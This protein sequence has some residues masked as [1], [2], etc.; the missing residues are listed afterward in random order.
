MKRTLTTP[1]LLFA[2]ADVILCQ[3]PQASQIEPDKQTLA[4]H[5]SM[6]VAVNISLPGFDFRSEVEQKLRETGIT[7]LNSSDQQVAYPALRLSLEASLI[8]RFRPP[9]LDYRIGLEFVQLFTLR[10]G[11]YAKAATWSANHSGLLPWNGIESATDVVSGVQKE[12]LNLVD[13]F[14][15][16]WRDVNSSAGQQQPEGGAPSGH[17]DGIWRGSYSCSGGFGGGTT[18]WRIREVTPGN[19]QIVEQWT[20]FISGRNSYQGRI[21][22]RTLDVTTVETSNGMSAYSVRLT[23]APDNST[24]NG[25]YSGHPNHCDTVTLE[26]SE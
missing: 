25:R 22:G 12:A 24:L 17:F 20:H 8:Q 23:L 5:G 3:R 1:I 10:T 21:T 13:R 11:R 16:D 6:S 7:V 4:G 26:K 19:V 14:I 15:S 2:L 18:V 9:Q